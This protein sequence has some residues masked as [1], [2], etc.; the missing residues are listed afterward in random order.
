METLIATILIVAIFVISSMVLNNLFASTVK[1]NKR[2]ILAKINELEYLYINEKIKHP[3]QDE[4]DGW[5]ITIVDQT[6][7]KTAKLEA[8]NNIS[9]QLIERDLNKQ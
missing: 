3:F 5:T 2:S 8:L 1:Q 6:N 7:S 4:H 9:N